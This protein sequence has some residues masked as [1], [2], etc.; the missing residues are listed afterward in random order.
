MITP[1]ELTNK[2]VSAFGEKM[3]L[4]FGFWRSDIPVTNTE[5]IYGCFF[6]ALRR[7]RD[8][9]SVS[10]CED[11][12]TCGGG[13]FY[14]GLTEM[15][16]R[17]PGFVSLKERYKRT[18]EDV[19]K[20]IASIDVK[21]N[22]YKYVNF[23]PLDKL[24]TLDH[25]EGLAFIVTPDVLSGLCGW[26]LFDNNSPDAV[27]TIFGSGCSTLFSNVISENEIGG[28]SC[29]LGLFDP[30]VRPQ[31]EPDELGFSIPKSRLVSMISTLDECFLADSH[32]WTFVKTRLTEQNR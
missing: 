7:L 8:G 9:I 6:K 12:I 17:V 24:E 22:P 30:S 14:L 26:A 2:L 29:F 25:I 15:P 32:A 31:V 13:K 11:N 20:F 19:C 3:A 27:R 16:E 28:M 10:L 23:Q 4:P 5:K 18:P 1:L 21:R